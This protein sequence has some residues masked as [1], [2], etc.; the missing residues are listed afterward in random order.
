MLIVC[1][2]EAFIAGIW[3]K[4]A[5]KIPLR[6]NSEFGLNEG[7]KFKILLEFIGGICIPKILVTNSTSIGVILQFQLFTH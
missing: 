1:L 5:F 4:P 3:V 6:V 7:R 2:E